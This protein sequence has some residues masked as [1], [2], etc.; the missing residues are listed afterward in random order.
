MNSHCG[1]FVNEYDDSPVKR[2]LII[3]TRKLSYFGDF[4]HDV[5]IMRK[6]KLKALKTSIKSFSKEFKN[7]KINEISDEK[8]QELINFHHLDIQ[9]LENEYSE[10]YIK[11]K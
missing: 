1:W 7:Y 3:P 5:E 10:K 11:S 2:I 8:I 9:S 6:G 4:T